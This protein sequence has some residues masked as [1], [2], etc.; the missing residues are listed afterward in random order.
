MQHRGPAGVLGELQ[1]A[2]LDATD[3][4][5]G[6]ERGLHRHDRE[7]DL[8]SV[9]SATTAKSGVEQSMALKPDVVIMDYHLPDGDG[10]T[11]A[12][13]I[14]ADAPQTRIVMLTVSEAERDLPENPE[15]AV[16]ALAAHPDRRDVRLLVAVTRDGRSRCLLR[17]RAH[18]SDDKVAMGDDI[19]PGLVHA[20][21]ATLQD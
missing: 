2:A 1:H 9:A 10:L 16:E 18:D 7:P 3:Q 14:L 19:A 21:R 8:R 4:V 11:A 6:G 5:A 12:A 15:K 17:Q 20:L 13:R